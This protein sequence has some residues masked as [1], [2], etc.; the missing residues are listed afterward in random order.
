MRLELL[1]LKIDCLE[2]N[3]FLHEI[4]LVYITCFVFVNDK[5]GGFLT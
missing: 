2:T 5:H 1:L 3:I 4:H